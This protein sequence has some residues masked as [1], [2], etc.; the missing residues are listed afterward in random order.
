MPRGPWIPRTIIGSLRH[1]VITISELCRE[2]GPL[3]LLQLRE[4]PTVLGSFV[5]SIAAS[6]IDASQKVA[7][8]SNDVVT[9]AGLGG[10]FEP[11]EVDI[12]ASATPARSW[13]CWEAS[14]SS[15]S[16]SPRRRGCCCGSAMSIAG[17]T[18]YALARS[19]SATHMLSKHK[20]II[21]NKM[22]AMLP[23]ISGMPAV[24]FCTESRMLVT[25]DQ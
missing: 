22:A 16:T 4:I 6:A 8:L 9:L 21:P 12:R 1:A 10:K 23:L 7:L 25:E 3:M 14:A 19:T 17:R 20:V 5:R 15:T 13:T 2:H 24:N 18:G 11:Q